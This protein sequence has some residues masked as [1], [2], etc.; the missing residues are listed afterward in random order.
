MNVVKSELRITARKG[1]AYSGLSRS[2]RLRAKT[3]W[4]IV[5][6]SG[7]SG[8]GSLWNYLC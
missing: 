3:C 4:A 2:S 6:L 8:R 7:E 1:E 5:R